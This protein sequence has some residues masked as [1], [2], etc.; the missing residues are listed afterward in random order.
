MSII[1]NKELI[2][3]SIPKCAS[4]SII[5]SLYNSSVDI[6]YYKKREFS[7]EEFDSGFLQEHHRVS[8]LYKIFGVKETVCIT[9][10]WFDRSVSCVK[11]LWKE[12]GRLNINPA[13]PFQELDNTFLLKIFDKTFKHT[14]YNESTF[15]GLVPI[16]MRFVDSSST[17]TDYQAIEFAKTIP[18]LKSQN[19]YKENTNCTYEFDINDLGSFEKFILERYNTQISVEKRN[20]GNPKSTKLILDNKLRECLWDT[21]EAP[22]QKNNSTI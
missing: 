5:H 9:R 3:V 7:N 11:Q 14:L 12:M 4:N 16:A 6:R 8:Y 21:F 22:L 10:D 1:I 20:P 13:I 2:F 19:W 17:I 18:V 15:E